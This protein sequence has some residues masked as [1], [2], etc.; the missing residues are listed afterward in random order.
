MIRLENDGPRLVSTNYW[1]TE[2]ATAGHLYLS[3]NAGALRV[4]IPSAQ[5][6]SSPDLL[7]DLESARLFVLSRGPWP[8]AG[9]ADALELL[10]DDD[11]DSPWVMH[12]GVE[13]IDRLP[14]DSESGRA[15]QVLVYTRG[16]RG[17]PELVLE[18]PG[19]YRRVKKLPHMKP[20]S[21]FD[22]EKR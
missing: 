16:F 11:T 10:A 14:P 17:V 12:L 22:E 5:L 21:P 9:R 19:R 18:R 8:A 4:L 20:W 6:R 3:I 1:E 2:N 15:L 13:S 7:S